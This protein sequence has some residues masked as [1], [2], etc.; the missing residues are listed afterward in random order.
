MSLHLFNI[1]VELIESFIID[2]YRLLSSLKL[3]SYSYANSNC[4]SVQFK[5]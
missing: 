4:R 5:K 2:G 1:L 3:A